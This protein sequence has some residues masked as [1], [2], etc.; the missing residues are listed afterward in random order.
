MALFVKL[1]SFGFLT[2]IATNTQ[3]SKLHKRW[4]I[5]ADNTIYLNL[6]GSSHGGF[7]DRI[8][9]VK[10]DT[11][12]IEFFNDGKFKSVEGDGTFTTDNDSLYLNLPEGSSSF[13]YELKD[14]SLYLHIDF[15]RDDY[16]RR[17]VLHAIPM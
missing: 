3:Y 9:S 15:L 2:L 17:E 14:S 6:D 16:I 8:D 10:S 4:K 7:K 5:I 12:F 11:V 13:K 1:I